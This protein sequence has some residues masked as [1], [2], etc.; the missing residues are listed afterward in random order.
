MVRGHPIAGIGLD[1]FL[2]RDQ[3]ESI[4]PAAWAEPNI[5][6]P[7]SWVLQFWLGLGLLGLVAALALL[8]RFFWLAV[9]QARRGRGGERRALAGGALA[10]MA[11]LLVHGALDNSYFLVDLAVLFWWHLALVEI[12]TRDRPT[13]AAAPTPTP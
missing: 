8:A 6:H 10:S 3:L 9:P 13:T 7:H 5:S 12:A 11:G 1:A 4:L 2:Y